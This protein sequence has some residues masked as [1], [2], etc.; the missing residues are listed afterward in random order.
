MK[1]AILLLLLIPFLSGVH[2]QYSIKFEV[3]EAIY[4][5]ASVVTPEEP[6][7]IASTFKKKSGIQEIGTCSEGTLGAE[8]VITRIGAGSTAYDQFNIWFYIKKG[9]VWEVIAVTKN[10]QLKGK[11]D[12]SE[13]FIYRPKTEDQWL[14]IAYSV[15]FE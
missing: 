5:G 12:W 15:V 11:P 3:T 10:V 7:L 13:K 9:K 1:K 4:T 14:E 2:A 8:F 6:V